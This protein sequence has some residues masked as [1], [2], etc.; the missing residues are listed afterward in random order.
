MR[1]VQ[2]ILLGHR[3]REDWPLFLSLALRISM[4]NHPFVGCPIHQSTVRAK[5][6]PFH[7]DGTR[8]DTMS[9][10]SRR[11]FIG[12]AAAAASLVG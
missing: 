1:R 10:V 2:T 8:G 12:S 3:K 5:G 4:T 9:E 7:D 6:R 11:G